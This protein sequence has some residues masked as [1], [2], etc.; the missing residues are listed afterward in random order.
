MWEALARMILKWKYLLLS[1]IILVTAYLGYHASLVKL[2]YEFSRA[3]PTDNPKFLEYQDFRQKFG[4]DGNLMVIGIQSNKIFEA[5]FF[6]D[7]AALA[8]NIRD[9]QGVEDV[10]GIPTATNLVKDTLTEKL[11]ALPVFP[12]QKISQQ[13]LDRLKSL[14]LSLPFYRNLLYN[15]NNAF[16]LAI[17]INKDVMNSAERIVTVGAITKLG[18]EFGN[19]HQVEIHFSGL[20]LIRT[21]LAVRIAAEMRWFLL[22]S[23]IISAIILLLFFRSLSAVLLSLSVVLIGVVWSF[24]TMHLLGYNITLLNALIPPL[25]VVIG[26]PNCI[27]FLNKYHTSFT[28]T[29]NKEKA[30]V[31]M[32]S[33]MGVVTLF[34][35]LT[36]AIGFAVFALTRSAILKEFGV[37]A[38]INIFLLFLISLFVIPSVLSLLPPPSVKHMRYLENRWLLA[39]LDKIEIWSLE[40]QKHIYAIT[41]IVV[42][43]AVAGIF[44]LKS[45]G[46]IVDD[47]PKSDI[48]YKDLKF[49]EQHFKG[50]M[51]L[52]VIVDTKRKN[53]L[54]N[55]PLQTY[56]KVDSFSKYLEAQPEMGKP[57]SI[58]EGLKFAKQAY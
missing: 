22:G 7:Y 18:Q 47:L 25:V 16:L 30:L 26:I 13:E 48:L 51:P 15:E 5:N 34:C 27:Y 37:V 33:R 49:F 6:N 21:S 52:E 20:P 54:R 55:N 14:F 9:V 39:V 56:E 43:I 11:Q 50:V 35:N 3:I 28:E 17:R 44:R 4:E 19:Q 8:K 45:E 40:H 53:G 12:N 23:L 1:V 36:A 42:G 32:I 58:V 46:F 29:G 38:G 10:L 31:S 57:L 24:G 2:S 41:I